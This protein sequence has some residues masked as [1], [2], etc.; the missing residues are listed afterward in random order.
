MKKTVALDDKYTASHGCAYMNGVQAQIR[1]VLIQSQCDQLFVALMIP[2]LPG[3]AQT[4]LRMLRRS[5][6]SA[7]GRSFVINMTFASLLVL[8]IFSLAGDQL[9]RI[10][11][12]PS[13]P[14]V[15]A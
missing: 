14:A 2:I 9:P 7:K 13:G 8:T 3:S 5:F 1:L 10:A 6:N 15:S 4:M 12:W 11:G